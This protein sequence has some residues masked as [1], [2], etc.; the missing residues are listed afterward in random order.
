MFDKI[1]RT[2]YSNKFG[3]DTWSLY[4]KHGSMLTWS[5]IAVLKEAGFEI[6]GVIDEADFFII[7]LSNRK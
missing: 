2:E 3:N 6:Y 4:F 5:D 7:Q 1:L